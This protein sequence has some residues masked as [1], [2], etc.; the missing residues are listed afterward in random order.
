MTAGGPKIAG[1][2]L[3]CFTPQRGKLV[4]MFLGLLM[5]TAF[6]AW[7]LLAAEPGDL[8]YIRYVIWA[9][10]VLCPVYAVDMGVRILRRTPTIV[11]TGEGLVLRTILGFAR[12]IPWAEIGEF[13]AVI[14]GKK[15][16]L[17]IYL[18]DP[19]ATL[20]AMDLGPRLMLAKSHVAGVPIQNAHRRPKLCTP[21]RFRST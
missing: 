15:P 20:G 8:G 1:E 2:V 11:A 3:D 19:R 14:M 12:P 17:A 18:E 21:F 6:A 4:V 9:V 13:R 7:L 5:F 10:L 16:W